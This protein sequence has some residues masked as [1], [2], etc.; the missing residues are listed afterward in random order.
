MMDCDQ[1]RRA[2]LA[3]PHGVSVEMRLHAAV[4]PECT[5][6][7]ERVQ[8]FEDRLDRALRVDIVPTIPARGLRGLGRRLGRSR[9]VR[10]RWLAAAAS[11]LLACVVAGSLWLAAPGASLAADVVSH[12]AGEPEAWT[13]TDVPVPQPQLEAVL[14][15]SHMRLKAD[16]GLVTYAS[17]CLFRGH[18]VPHLVVQTA[19]GPVTV[20]VL[21]HEAT[22]G[23]QRFN[24]QGYQ[25]VIEAMPG[26]G[27]L[28]VLERGSAFDERT[29]DAVIT[30]VQNA[31]DWR[32]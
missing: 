15:E 7:T 19:A 6:Y 24:D 18:Q 5:R 14:S 1:Y 17:S 12:M 2:L 8:R 21:T 26:H 4:C 29:I 32:G 27:S 31:I 20:M 22:R 16:A 13:R 28:A 25:G 10:R 11:L 3:D 30:Q 23:Q 9:R